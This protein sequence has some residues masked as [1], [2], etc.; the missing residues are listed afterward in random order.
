MP[1]FDLS[2][3]PVKTG[4]I[5]PE[6]YASE[7]AGRSSQRLGALGGLT[8][9]G[10]NIVTLAP[11]AVASLQHW[12]LNED[13]FAMVLEGTLILSED[14]KETPMEPGDCAAWQAG[15]PVGHRLENRS[16]APARFLIVGSRADEEVVT[17][18]QVD[19]K[20]HL[21]DGKARFTYHDETDWIGPRKLPDGETIS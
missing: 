16:N 8:Q 13:E 6:P 10:V 15:I 14:T 11:G 21:A 3:A 18:T 5:Y 20:A 9:F 17:Y 1:K 4:S 2:R 7:M 19:M 12:H